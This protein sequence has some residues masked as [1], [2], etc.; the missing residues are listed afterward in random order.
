MLT[1]RCLI[2]SVILLLLATV[3]VADLEIIVKSN[4]DWGEISVDDM[5]YLSEEVADR[6]EDHLRTTNEINDNV[7]LYRTITTGYSLVTLV[8]YPL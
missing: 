6:F 3:V 2:L 1:K 7:N 4:P 5:Q 8:V